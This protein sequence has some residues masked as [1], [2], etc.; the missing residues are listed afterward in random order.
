MLTQLTDDLDC[1]RQKPMRKGTHSCLECRRRKVRCT[2]EPHAHK[3]KGC[4]TRDLAC[5]NQ[6]YRRSRSPGLGER[7]STRNRVR[8]LEGILDQVLHSQKRIN[9]AIDC[10][11]ADVAVLEPRAGSGVAEDRISIVAVQN[12]NTKKREK[13]SLLDP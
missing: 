10:P 4:L 3:C 1:P 9:K 6:D 7:I 8:E 13:V 2:F 12:G 5:P 11:K